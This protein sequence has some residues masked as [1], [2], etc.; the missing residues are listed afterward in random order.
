MTAKPP[1]NT[2][3]AMIERAQ[4]AVAIF[5]RLKPA[6][7]LQPARIKIPIATAIWSLEALRQTDEESK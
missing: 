2:I 6:P 3:T 7:P 1:M 5:F 4:R